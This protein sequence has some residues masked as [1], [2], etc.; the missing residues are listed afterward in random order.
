MMW[1]PEDYA[2]NSDAQLK[3]ARELR[4][5]LDLQGNESV[6]DVGCGDGKITA[7]F[8]VALPRGKVVGV[9]SSTQMID[10]ATRTYADTKYPNLSFA[11]IDARSLEFDD[12][13]NL[14]FS[15]ATLH[16]VDNH[17]AFLQ[18]VSR[19]LRSGGRLIVGCGGKGCAVDVLQ[20][21]SELVASKPWSDRFDNFYNPYY[22]YSDEEYA[23]WLEESG[24]KVEQLALVPKDMTHHGKEGL[25][26]WIRTTW[27][28]FTHRVPENEREYFIS[29]F[30]DTYLEQIPLDKDGLAHVRMV[31]LEVNALKP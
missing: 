6:L 24:F 28:P 25:A 5:K 7:D 20:V 13:F 27:M 18:G 22:F 2:K 30:V 11:C 23:V 21:F 16:W 9:D 1:N 31:R 14:V 19:A 4:A 29:S 8:A 26:G 15:N 10:Y 12:E 3:W 17:Q